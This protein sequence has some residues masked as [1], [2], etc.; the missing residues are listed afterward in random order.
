MSVTDLIDVVESRVI[1]VVA[2]AG[3]QEDQRF[4]VADFV[5]QIQTPNDAVHL[6]T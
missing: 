3:S 1:E 4:Q 5:R 2:Y 6:H